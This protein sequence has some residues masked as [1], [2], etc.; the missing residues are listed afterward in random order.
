VTPVPRP[1]AKAGRVENPKRSVRGHDGDIGRG[2]RA[3]K[4]G[5]C[6]D[7]ARRP[8]TPDIGWSET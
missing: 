5:A 1:G 2:R 8:Y 4:P 7:A 3:L 6:S